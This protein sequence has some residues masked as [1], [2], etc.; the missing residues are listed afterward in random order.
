MSRTYLQQWY[1]AL[2]L[3]RVAHTDLLAPTYGELFQ[4]ITVSD[5][6]IGSMFRRGFLLVW[7]HTATGQGR[8]CFENDR[9]G[10]VGMRVLP[11]LAVTEHFFCTAVG[12]GVE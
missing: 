12:E 2:V 6:E 7:L 3:V 5:M 10:N 4:G 1:L 11:P 9:A 8:K